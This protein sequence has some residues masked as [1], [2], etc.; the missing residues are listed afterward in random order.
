MTDHDRP[1]SSRV[2]PCPDAEFRPVT[3][4]LDRRRQPATRSVA[5][6]RRVLVNPA[7]AGSVRA[8]GSEARSSVP[9]VDDVP[10]WAL[11]VCGI[12]FGILMLLALAL[13]GGPAYA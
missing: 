9:V 1:V 10:T 8:C 5:P 13:L 6:G 11:V 2:R 3:R 7:S 4:T 12:V